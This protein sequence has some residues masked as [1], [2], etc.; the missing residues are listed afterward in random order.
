MCFNSDQ[1][2]NSFD[3]SNFRWGE[4]EPKTPE[5]SSV[6]SSTMEKL[7]A[8]EF[9]I[10]YLEDSWNASVDSFLSSERQLKILKVRW[11]SGWRFD[12]LLPPIMG[13]VF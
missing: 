5:I 9:Q 1:G 11:I 10:P 7:P 3:C 12:D 6:L 13:N 4:C 8:L 2:S